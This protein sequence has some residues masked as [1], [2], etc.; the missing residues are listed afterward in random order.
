MLEHLYTL[1]ILMLDLLYTMCRALV[2]DP[3][4]VQITLGMDNE[5]IVYEV[6][7]APGDVGKV[8]GKEGRIGN[9]LRTIVKSAAM[10]HKTKVYVKILSTQTSTA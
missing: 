10:K 4:Q 3:D 8:I 6:A 7:V 5:T 2:D 9:A 1:K